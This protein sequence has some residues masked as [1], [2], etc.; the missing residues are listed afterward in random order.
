VY[1][2]LATGVSDHT[3]ETMFDGVTQLRG[4]ECAVVEAGSARP[5]MAVRRWYRLLDGS[6]LLFLPEGEAAGRFHDALTESVRLH[7]RSDV[8]VGSCLSGGL[9]S[10]SIVCLMAGM[11]QSADAGDGLNT[12]SACYVEK[13]VDEKPFMDAVVDHTNA[14]PH[15]VFPRAEDV[16]ARAADI[17]WF[18]D[19]PF[20]S[21]SI[22]AQWCVFG[23][24]RRAGIKV[25][26]DGQ[27]ADEQL[28][29]Y[30]SGFNYYLSDLVRRGRLMMLVKTLSE[31]AAVHGQPLK[32]QLWHLAATLLPAGIASRL[33]R[34]YRAV[35][36]H[37]WLASDLLAQYERIP[38]A[39]RLA[40]DLLQLPQPKDIAT[41][42]LGLTY[43]SN[44]PMLLHWEDRSS[45]AHSIEARVPFVDHPLVEFSLMLGSQ[46]KIVGGETKRVLR[47]AMRGVLPEPVR[48][49][50]DKLGFATPE[51]AWFRG[52]LRGAALDGVEATLRRYPGLLSGPGVRLLAADMLDGKRSMDFTLW[53]IINLGIWGER[54]SVGV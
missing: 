7:L 54:F 45:M 53:R 16:F 40:V 2:F 41:L 27:G 13:S 14:R 36:Q 3:A 51:E 17:T 22:F 10:S 18:Q 29:G 12:V 32:R 21:T 9:D 37:D 24:A 20:G 15:Y 44:L 4:G 11:L 19:E 6:G 46:H 28:A 38:S 48:R 34:R 43:A 31:R 42:C 23:E 8:P 50:T 26:L 49:R 52:P 39:S 33:R 5:T 47:M 1:D 25:M 35:V 30:H